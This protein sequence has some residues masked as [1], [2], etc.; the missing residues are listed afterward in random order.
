MQE[1]NL[2]LEKY[3]ALFT[4]LDSCKIVFD[5]LAL[6]RKVVKKVILQINF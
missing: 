1:K 3:L 6:S 5:N 4:S 2:L